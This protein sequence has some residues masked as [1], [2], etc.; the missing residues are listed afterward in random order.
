MLPEWANITCPVIAI[1]GKQDELVPYENL[2]FLK[3][4]L[5]NAPVE[6]VTKENMNHFVPWSDPDLI[7]QAV[8]K[9]VNRPKSAN[10]NNKSDL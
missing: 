5:I 2:L 8:L 1:Q 9:M 6:Y 4:M 10:I 7:Q 3:K